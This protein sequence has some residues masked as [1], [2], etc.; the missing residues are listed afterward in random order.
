MKN[1]L[2]LESKN[3]MV[4]TSQVFKA[5]LYI[6]C[7][8]DEI[9]PNKWTVITSENL[10]KEKFSK[11]YNHNANNVLKYVSN[12]AKNSALTIT[13]TVLTDEETVKVNR[14]VQLKGKVE[15]IVAYTYIHIGIPTFISSKDVDKYI[16]ITYDQI[17]KNIKDY[18]DI[19]TA[20]D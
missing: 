17:T 18:Y 12:L 2:C 15:K 9:S 1:I 19:I 3:N 5:A 10:A 6:L 11:A 14:F 7:N 13:S 20:L 16:K 8:S 4:T